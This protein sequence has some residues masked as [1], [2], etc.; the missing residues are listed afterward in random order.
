LN[1]AINDQIKNELESYYLYLSMAAWLHSRSLDG[2]GHWMRCQAH[3][4]MIHAMKLF[5]HVIERG[6]EVKLLDLKQ[7]KTAWS[8]P[9]EAF[10]DAD[11]HEKFITDKIRDLT[12]L[13]R[14]ESEF[15]SEP[16]LAW[17][18][19][20]QIEEESHTGKIVA[21]LER[22]GESKEG[23]LMIDRELA[24]R[25]FPAGSPFDPVAVSAPCPP[26]PPYST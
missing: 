14:E 25:V 13:C 16:T 8:S 26:P 5:D 17:F 9:L 10:Q 3:E 1:N 19:E 6:G 2:M 21:D 24:A 15:P 12:K 11:N 7:L 20:E 23:L 22:I 4:E 18:N